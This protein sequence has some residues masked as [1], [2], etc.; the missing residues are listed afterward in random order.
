M[1][2]LERRKGDRVVVP[3]TRLVIYVVKVSD[4]KVTLGFEAPHSVDIFRGEIFDRMA[5]EEWDRGEPGH[6]EDIT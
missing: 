4:G 5:F 3:C 6:E 2:E 1:L